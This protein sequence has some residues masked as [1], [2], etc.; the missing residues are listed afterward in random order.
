MF[1]R[2][3]ALV[4]LL[5]ASLAG[6]FFFVYLVLLIPL[7]VDVVEGLAPLSA[8]APRLFEAVS[9]LGYF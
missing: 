2:I 4:L 8:L 1:F 5:A 3:P 6:L 7:A 9:G